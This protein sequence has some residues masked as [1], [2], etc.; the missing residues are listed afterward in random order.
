MI[1]LHPEIKADLTANVKRHLALFA[2]T[3][4]SADGNN[5][6]SIASETEM[7]ARVLVQLT[8]FTIE[9]GKLPLTPNPKGT[10]QCQYSN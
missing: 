9:H 3:V 6:V 8:V 4:Q 2:H 10:S 1:A 7:L 5:P